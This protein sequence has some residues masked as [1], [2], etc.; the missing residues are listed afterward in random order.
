MG[1]QLNDMLVLTLVMIGTGKT[2]HTEDQTDKSYDN[3]Y[4]AHGSLLLA[5]LTWLHFLYHI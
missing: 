5:T 4:G 2:H 1:V 3:I